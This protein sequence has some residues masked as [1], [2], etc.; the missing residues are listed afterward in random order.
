VNRRQFLG[1][2]ADTSI[3]ARTPSALAATYDLVIKGGG[4]IDPSLAINAIVDVAIAGNRIVAVEV[5]ILP[6]LPT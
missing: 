5:N 4:V 6:M 2:L 1:T 3:L